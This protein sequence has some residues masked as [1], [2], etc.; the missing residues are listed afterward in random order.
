MYKNQKCVINLA[1]TEDILRFPY[2]L[3]IAE[4]SL[5]FT[6]HHSNIRSPIILGTAE[7][8]LGFAHILIMAEGSLGFPPYPSYSK[9]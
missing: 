2:I 5:H 4:D 3:V 1:I 6:P 8:N 7:N 9:I